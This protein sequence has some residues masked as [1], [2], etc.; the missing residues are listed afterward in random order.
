MNDQNTRPNREQGIENGLTRRQFLKTAS[1]ATRAALT[2]GTYS[3][4]RDRGS[5][6]SERNETAPFAMD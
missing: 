2:A 6:D 5:S 4:S 1:W 3:Y